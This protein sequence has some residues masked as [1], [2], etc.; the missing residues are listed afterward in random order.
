M[1]LG[2]RQRALDALRRTVGFDKP[3]DAARFLEGVLEVELARLGEKVWKVDGEAAVR[4]V[5]LIELQALHAA[6]GE[7]LQ[8]VRLL[9]DKAAGR[10]L[11]E[12]VKPPPT[13]GYGYGE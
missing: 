8:V 1:W 2:M 6:M 13:T 7:M 3:I 11:P 9:G 10:A 5:A 4:G 12:P